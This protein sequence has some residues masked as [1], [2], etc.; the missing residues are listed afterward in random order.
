MMTG[1]FGTWVR[2]KAL[3]LLM[4]RPMLI[5]GATL[6]LAARRE[7]TRRFDRSDA[8]GGANARRLL[9]SSGRSAALVAIQAAS[10]R[11]N[12]PL[13]ATAV[14]R[15]AEDRPGDRTLQ[16]AAAEYLAASAPQDAVRVLERV[17]DSTLD[18]PSSATFVQ[19]LTRLESGATFDMLVSR[20][21]T[22]NQDPDARQLLA[23]AK[24]I[25]ERRRSGD[26]LSTLAHEYAGN[27]VLLAAL[28]SWSVDESRV[29]ELR[30]LG[31][32]MLRADGMDPDVHLDLARRLRDLGEFSTSTALAERVLTRHPG[33]PRARTIVSSGH[34]VLK[35]LREGWSPPARAPRARGAVVGPIPYLLHNALPHV[36][37]GYATRT[38]G[39]LTALR[40]HGW[41]VQGVTRPGF[42]LDVTDLKAADSVDVVDGVPY[43]HLLRGNRTFPL[44][45]VEKSLTS[46]VRE[47]TPFVRERSVPLVHAASNYRNGAAG[48]TVARELGVP[49][50]YEVR[51]LWEFTRLVRQ[52]DYAETEHHAVTV[53]M[54]TAVARES[55]RVIAITEALKDVLVDRG[56]SAERISVVPNGVDTRRFRPLDRDDALAASLGVSGKTVIG[57]IGS[58]VEYEGLEL[59]IEAAAS[60]RNV[61]D[62]FAVLI[63]GDGRSL[64]ELQS[65]ARELGMEERVIFPGRVPHEAVERYYSI[66]DVAP[67]P[68]LP[69]SVCELVS[70]LK[71]FEAMAMGKLVVASDV[72]ALAEIIQDG[73]NGRLFTKGSAASL[74]RVL[75]EVIDDRAAAR[76][77]A[78]RGMEWVRETRDWSTIARSIGSIYEELGVEPGLLATR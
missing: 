11:A 12:A 16:M 78:E 70:P 15:R 75:E 40:S 35:T 38:H 58:L 62:D 13:D 30:S 3:A 28:S 41:D 34:S 7:L 4:R 14:L 63:V 37:V 24:S 76:S 52:P 6:E 74:A 23:A 2:G 26:S 25:G 10:G 55:D 68:R 17:A 31:A 54:E 5:R 57:Y 9:A 71:P 32:A 66:I 43:H 49:A 60:L 61:R 69:V 50:I 53:M 67:F 77:V 64:P 48:V 44:F 47:L 73:E 59:L 39:L 46:F 29:G 42:P 21:L 1:T 19:V 72:A 27:A 65:Q 8:A 18:L 36:S 22:S 56:V 51:G 33:M 20:A 45:P